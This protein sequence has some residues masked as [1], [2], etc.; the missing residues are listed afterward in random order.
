MAASWECTSGFSA[1]DWRTVSR[2]ARAA[3][4]SPSW[5]RAPAILS[6]RASLDTPASAIFARQRRASAGRF[7]SRA[8]LRRTHSINSGQPKASS[9]SRRCSNWARIC[10]GSAEP[11][12]CCSGTSELWIFNSSAA[13]AWYCSMR[14][15]SSSI[16]VRRRTTWPSAPRQSTS[17]MPN[18]CS[19][20]QR[21]HN[22]SA[23]AA[24]SPQQF[25][26]RYARARLYLSSHTDSSTAWW[27][28]A[29]GGAT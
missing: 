24:A 19:L 3:S 27:A 2:S 25:P 22:A 15:P 6:L 29:A 5:A 1:S 7:S 17:K 9:R 13:S 11:S 10:W 16:T 23:S 8:W 14:R 4:R 28:S 26:S 21:V 18:R 20:G 12:E